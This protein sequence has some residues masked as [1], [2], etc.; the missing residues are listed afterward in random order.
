M[1]D[2]RMIEDAIRG[3]RCLLKQAKKDNE[4][5]A[6]LEN[7]RKVISIRKRL[8]IYGEMKSKGAIK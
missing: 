2:K 6:T 8:S 5:L 1:D 4:N 3:A 7:E